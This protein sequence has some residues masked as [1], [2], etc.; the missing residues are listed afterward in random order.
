MKEDGIGNRDIYGIDIA[1]YRHLDSYR[2]YIYQ[3]VTPIITLYLKNKDVL[4]I[5]NEIYFYYK[6]MS[7]Q[8]LKITVCL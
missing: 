2:N 3:R 8:M 7:L 5:I 6:V 1:I 4:Y